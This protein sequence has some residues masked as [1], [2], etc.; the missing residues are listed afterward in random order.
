MIDSLKWD[1]RFIKKLYKIYEEMFESFRMTS[2]SVD[3]W[4]VL[5][6]FDN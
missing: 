3:D 6:Y 2:G 5:V 1:K 4:K